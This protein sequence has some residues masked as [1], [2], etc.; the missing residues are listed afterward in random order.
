MAAAASLV[1]GPEID[2][3]HI[4]IITRNE[5]LDAIVL[6][7]R[8]RNWLLL[9]NDDDDDINDCHCSTTVTRGATRS[10]R[11]RPDQNQCTS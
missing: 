5:S 7:A 8:E 2:F 6:R 10:E 4:I 9:H 3:A 1:L 11:F